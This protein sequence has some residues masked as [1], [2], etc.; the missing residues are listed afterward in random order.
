MS[1]TPPSQHTATALAAKAAMEA[2]WI[3]VFAAGV[4]TSEQGDV[5]PITRAD[6]VA[7]AAAYDP[8]L[9]EAPLVIGHPETDQPAYGYI[10]ELS[11]SAP[12]QD[13]LL[14]RVHQ[15]VPEFAEQAIDGGQLKKRSL[16]FYHWQDPRN[17]KPG[18]LYPRHL[19]SLGAQPPAVKGLA[20]IKPLAASTTPQARFAEAPTRMVSFGESTT[21]TAPRSTTMTPEEIAKLKADKAAADKAAADALAAQKKAEDE[22]KALRDKADADANAAAAARHAAN[23]AFAESAC[24]KGQTGA[25]I[26]PAD[27][28]KLVAAL[29]ALGAVHVA[30]PMT[31]A[32]GDKQVGFDPV[33]WVKQQ[34][35]RL[36]VQVNFSEHVPQGTPA[37]S[38]DGGGATSPVADL[39]PSELDK[40]IK[41]H[42]AK[43]QGMSYA[44]ASTAVCSFGG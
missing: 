12:P 1:T 39:S 41:A 44:E 9:H 29:D 40:R 28:S 3:E 27:K 16:A 36:P 19:G 21:A 4:Q 2:Q 11:V 5:Y 13:K 23:M 24:G 14:A 6:L 22:A 30:K 7:T 33:D 38:F 37:E 25:R 35:N 18:V 26:L 42:M 8:A 31:F 32:E 10:K 34:I 15:V 43:H 17:P 20:D